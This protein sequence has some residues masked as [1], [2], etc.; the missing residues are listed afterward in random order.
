MR[1]PIHPHNAGYREPQ[2][3]IKSR[4]QFINLENES[5]VSLKTA[6]G[7]WNKA[8]KDHELQGHRLVAGP[9][10]VSGGWNNYRFQ[11]EYVF[12]Y[13]NIKYDEE[14]SAYDAAMSQ[15]E[16][17]MKAYQEWQD[18]RSNPNTASID[19]KIERTKERLANLEAM[20]AGQPL[21][22]P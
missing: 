10:I 3:V 11:I 21:P 15:Y 1:K 13:D 14:K 4:D 2:R 18:N 16:L 5:K 17:D 6:I 9:D 7:L 20:K 22:Y 19:A 12:E 8:W